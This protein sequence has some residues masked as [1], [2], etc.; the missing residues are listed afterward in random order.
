MDESGE[1]AAEIQRASATAPPTVVTSNGGP[2]T[3]EAPGDRVRK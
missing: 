1:D 2:P 3:S